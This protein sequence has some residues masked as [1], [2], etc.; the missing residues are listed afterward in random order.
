MERKIRKNPKYAD[1][2]PDN[3]LHW[4]YNLRRLDFEAVHDSVLVIS[5]T[6][7]LKMGGP[8]FDLFEPNGNYVK[9][10]APKKA[11]PAWGEPSL[12]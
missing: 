2:D 3:K 9:V 1:I 5:G 4:R 7:D 11:L 6:L 10:Y 12:L 8:G